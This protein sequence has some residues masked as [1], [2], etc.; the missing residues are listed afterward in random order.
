MENLSRIH[1]NWDGS[2]W[3]YVCSCW[4]DHWKCISW[5]ANMTPLSF[6][7]EDTHIRWEGGT[8]TQFHSSNTTNISYKECKFWFQNHVCRWNSV[9]GAWKAAVHGPH[10]LPLEWKKWLIQMWAKRMKKTWPVCWGPMSNRL[11]QTNAGWCSTLTSL[12]I[13]SSLRTAQ[14]V[15]KPCFSFGCIVYRRLACKN[16]LGWFDH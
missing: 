11:T 5:E 12:L 15:R 10:F 8:G 2:W 4:H 1:A 13:C 7:F 9:R 3:F 14:K 6:L 16:G